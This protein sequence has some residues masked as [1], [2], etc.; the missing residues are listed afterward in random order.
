MQVQGVE[1]DARV[2]RY[3]VSGT[4]YTYGGGPQSHSPKKGAFW[5]RWIHV[6]RH[7]RNQ[8]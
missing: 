5:V 3:G 6:E 7:K 2:G 4:L 1:R 8:V